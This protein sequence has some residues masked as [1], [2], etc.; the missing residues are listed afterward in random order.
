MK[1]KDHMYSAVL[2]LSSNSWSSLPVQGSF[3]YAAG[4]FVGS[5]C[6]CCVYDITLATQ[7]SAI[8]D[9]RQDSLLKILVIVLFDCHLSLPVF[10]GTTY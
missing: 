8:V 9:G 3:Y 10:S 1:G 4:S 2:P 6:L 5:Y 7:A